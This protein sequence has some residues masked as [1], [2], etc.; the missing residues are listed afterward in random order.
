M[1]ASRLVFT[2]RVDLFLL[3]KKLFC[4]VDICFSDSL[5]LNHVMFI[6]I[7]LFYGV[8]PLN[9]LISP[10]LTYASP[11]PFKIFVIFCF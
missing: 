2:I 4:N 11:F 5:I 3:Y 10:S 6:I 8:T 1:V 7:Y 9:I